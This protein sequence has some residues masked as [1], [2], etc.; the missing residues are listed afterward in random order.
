M[1]SLAEPRRSAAALA[2]AVLA[3]AWRT[4]ELPAARA[5]GQ[6]GVWLARLQPARARRIDEPL[7]SAPGEVASRNLRRRGAEGGQETDRDGK[8][9]NQCVRRPRT[10]A[11]HRPSLAI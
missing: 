9:E 11:H 7:A 8:A 5:I 6:H 10:A 4:G 2:R 3:L 1:Y